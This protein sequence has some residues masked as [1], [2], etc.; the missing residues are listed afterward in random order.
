MA[1]GG[2]RHPDPLDMTHRI[3][4]AAVVGGQPDLAG[5]RLQRAP[6]HMQDQG[7]PADQAQGFA[8][9]AAGGISGRDG[10]YEI[11]GTGHAHTRQ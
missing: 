5:P 2:Q 10:D 1:G 7:L 3:G 4:H 8:R 9:Q 6:G 11:V